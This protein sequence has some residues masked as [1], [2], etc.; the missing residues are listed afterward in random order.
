MKNLNIIFKTS[1]SLLFIILLANNSLAQLVGWDNKEMISIQENSNTLKLNYQVLITLNTQTLIA[2]NQMQPNGE[3]IRFAKDCNGTSLYNYFIESGI[4]TANTKIWVLIDSLPANGNRIIHLFY[5]NSSA[6]AASN[7][8]NTFPPSSRLIV[9]TGSVTLSG[10]NNYSWFEIQSGASVI[11][12]PNSPFNINARMIRIAGTLNGNGAGYLGGA[13][14]TNG[15]GP[16]GGQVSSGNLGSFGAGGA[17]YGGL[18]GNGGGAGSATPSTVGQPGVVYGSFNTDSIEMGSG[19]GGSASGGAGGA[20][21]AGITLNGDEV[22]ITGVINANGSN[23]AQAVLNG[24]GGGGSGGGIKINGYSVIFNGTLNANGGNGEAGGYGSG[25]GGGGRIKIFS[26]ASL[27]NTGTLSVIGGA[28][29]APNNETVPQTDGNDGT[30]FIGTYTS[31]TPTFTFIPTPNVVL[32]ASSTTICQGNPITFNA[33]TGFS[34]YNFFI[35]ENSIQDSTANMFTS[36]SL[37]NN[38][39]VKVLATYANTCIDTSNQI[40]ITVNSN[41]TITLSSAAG[42]DAQTV[43]QNSS[44]TNITYNVTGGATGANATGLPTGVTG[45][46]AGGVFTITG[47]PTVVGSFNY[48]VITSGAC[49]ADSASGT[50]TINALPTIVANASAT[51]ICTGDSVILTGS[52]GNSYTWDNG[53]IDGVAF[54]PNITTTYTVVGTDANGCQNTDNITITVTNCNQPIASFTASALTICQGDSITFTDNSAGSSISNWNWTF[55]GGSSNS[56]NT[57]GPHTVVFN[58]SGSFNITL[59]ITDANGVDDTTIT[60]TVNPTTSFTQTFNECQG[61]SITV[62]SN[63]YTSTGVFTDILTGSNGCDSTVTTDLTINTVDTSTSTNANTITANATN[64]T[65][66]W[67]DCDN[68]NAVIVGE[69]NQSFTP[70]TNGNYAVE[71][72]QN[73][74]TDTSSCINITGVGLEEFNK[75]MVSI[76]P[77]PTSSEITINLENVLSS[78]IGYTLTTLEGK[79][80]KQNHSV[81][82]NNIEID[83]SEQPKGIYLLKIETDMSINVN[84]II[85]L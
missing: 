26:D 56:A 23:G 36:T 66:R 18:G 44:I 60:I 15:S 33:T 1:C 77:N 5:G 61:F 85:K 49:S 11:V 83:M 80:I 59:E 3:D 6:A 62:G 74:C 19:G 37:N 14:G 78:N 22:T 25:G 58:N 7:F 38:D 54:I 84:K 65:F 27:V 50:I 73:N 64:A 8:D 32:T 17:S 12:G 13:P 70:T 48:T 71:V 40:I 4:N 43:C 24:A 57:Q 20:G 28:A 75:V 9:S 52:G 42:T 29:G 41:D 16:G 34:N 67:L 81:S 68:N 47:T 51:T 10:T 35:N 76:Y 2:A 30:T 69:T 79:I 63:T 53:V 31:G 55:G 21:G 45:S 46:F 82:S 72:T 39:T